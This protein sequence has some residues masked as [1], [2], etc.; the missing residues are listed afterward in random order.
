[1]K[2]LLKKIGDLSIPLV[3]GIIAALI[4]ANT[5]FAS[6][7]RFVYGKFWGGAD[8][9]FLVNDVFLVFFFGLVSVEIVHGM[10]PGGNLFPLRSTVSN[11][12]GACGGV[13]LPIGIF[14]TLNHF[15]GSPAY[16]HGWAVPTATDVAISLLFA[17]LIFDRHH[18]AYTFLLLLAIA[19]D[20]IGL[21]IIAFF[22]PDPETAVELKWLLWIVAGIGVAWAMWRA[23]VKSYW[24]Y[25]II[26]G[27]LVWFGM[28]KANLHPSLALILIIPFIPHG[29]NL[30][31]EISELD[32]FEKLFQPIVNYGLFCF[33]LSNAGVVFSSVS[34][35]TGIIF[36]ALLLGKTCG[37]FA[38]TKLG[39]RLGFPINSR[40]TTHD[41]LIVSMVAG[42]GLTVSLFVADI[43]YTDLSLK[44]A[45]KM[46][47]LLSL[48]NG[49]LAVIAGKLLLKKKI[50]L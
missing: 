34:N 44:D 6:Y 16:T 20:V 41:L 40:I 39:C 29:K 50:D 31:G 45:A 37:I 48:F 15:I 14:F 21:V 42:I 49:F 38:F 32:K 8:F 11:L 2:L 24:L 36:I 5:D 13:L 23:K 46:G 35:L 47:A 18:P 7:H 4:W 9:H 1:M 28:H 10:E 19:D 30:G 22:Y 12:L 3:A 27:A 33:G 17:G 26:A 43:A 25:I